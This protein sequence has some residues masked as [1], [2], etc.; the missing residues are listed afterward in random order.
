MIGT[1][2]LYLL[3][4]GRILFGIFFMAPVFSQ[5]LAYND[6]YKIYGFPS[7][8]PCLIVGFI[9]GL[10]ANIKGQWF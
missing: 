6:I 4:K 10:Y 5:L 1:M 8:I 7:I 9:W 2:F 3:S